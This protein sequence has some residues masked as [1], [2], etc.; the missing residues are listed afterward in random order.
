MTLRT[1][2]QS[3][4]LTFGLGR[5][6][7]GTVDPKTLVSK[8]TLEATLVTPNGKSVVIA[9]SLSGAAITTPQHANLAGIAPGPAVL[10]LALAVTTKSWK[11]GSTTVPGTVLE[12]QVRDYPVTIQ[13]PASYPSAPD[14]VNLGS[15]DSSSSVKGSIP[16]KGNGCGWISGAATIKGA[17]SGVRPTV[18]STASDTAHCAAG[19]IPI[20]VDLHGSGN[21]LLAGTT[22][23]MLRSADSGS[24][25]VAQQVQFRL[26]MSRPANS[27]VLWGV[28]IGLVLLGLLIPLA[29]LYAL[30][31]ATAKLRGSAV[32][33]GA[34][35]GRVDEGSTFLTDR[36]TLVPAETVTMAVDGRRQV[37]ALGKTFRARMSLLPTEAGYVVVDQPRRPGARGPSGATAKEFARLPL[38]LV[39]TWLVSLDPASPHDGDV[40]VVFLVD[41]GMNGWPELLR[42][43]IS[44][45]PD[46]VRTLRADLPSSTGTGSTESS[47]GGWGATPTVA[48][49]WGGSS[50]ETSD[51]WGGGSQTVGTATA[52]Q[53][54]GSTPPTTQQDDP[55]A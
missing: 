27:S 18:A 43:A 9:R 29:L 40:E 26:D 35:R 53:A 34:L 23:V 1:G 21:G 28:L 30:K 42:D 14:V 17:P 39:N 41:P 38:G 15:T 5:A 20:T 8:T 12:P 36:S 47:G 49:T 13:V 55:W 50:S 31:F 10:R 46:V 6:S 37:S 24:A 52:G 2:G 11:N 19:S 16:L 3:P 22:T 48:D 51:P 44:H 32:T 33:V 7:G 54:A 4:A 25:P 45:M